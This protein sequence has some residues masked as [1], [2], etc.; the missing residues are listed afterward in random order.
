MMLF[1]SLF[2]VL[3]LSVSDIFF[4]RLGW[5][6]AEPSVTLLPVFFI[7]TLFNF[8]EKI[9]LL[10]YATGFRYFLLFLGMSIL[11][12]QPDQLTPSTYIIGNHGITFF[13]F[14]SSVLFFVN[15]EPN[16]VF[17]IFLFSFAVLG[18]SIL[19]DI[20]ISTTSE[21]RGSG[22][23]ENPNNAALRIVFLLIGI[24]RF[25]ERK[26]IALFF[27]LLTFLLVSLTLS[28]SGIITLVAVFFIYFPVK[29][30]NVR[31]IRNLPKRILFYLPIFGLLLF[32]LSQ[33][34]LILPDYL[35]T[36]EHR[37]ALERIEQIAGRGE[38]LTDSDVEG[39]RVNILKDYFDL[40]L[41]NLIGYGTG[42][43]INR[44]F[45]DKAT[46]NMFLRFAIDYGIIGV[47][48]LIA[49]IYSFFRQSLMSNN[50]YMFFLIL[51]ASIA[52]FF[53]HSLF[54]NRTFIIVLAFMTVEVL[55][56]RNIQ[57]G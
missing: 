10:K 16:R 48:S 27:C 1:I 40:F 54:E 34:V 8:S 41:D 4:Y 26:W 29:F 32:L 51:A 35:I 45:Y 49:F 30:S 3:F 36:F 9:Y 44:A 24:L 37:A 55:R 31:R 13:L 20:F 53:T 50:F 23:A 25:V 52:C 43:S 21:I 47:I 7:I 42:Y 33:V 19:Y 18:G 2:V 17:G 56:T 57:L 11:F 39:G 15:V 28:R 12:L 5:L 38:L 14:I 46:H 22:F 6:P